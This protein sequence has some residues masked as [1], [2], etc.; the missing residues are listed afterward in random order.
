VTY[1]VIPKPNLNFS[2]PID[3]VQAFDGREAWVVA[4]KDRPF[5]IDQ[6]FQCPI[7]MP[8]LSDSH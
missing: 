1:S 6:G 2:A 3:T 4:N 5:V 7:L 8:Q